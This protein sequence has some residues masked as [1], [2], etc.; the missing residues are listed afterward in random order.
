M[1]DNQCRILHRCQ[2]R[3]EHKCPQVHPRMRQ[4]QTRMLKAQFPPEQQ[5]QIQ[6]A[7]PPALLDLASNRSFCDFTGC[8][9]RRRD[10]L[11][12]QRNHFLRQQWPSLESALL[13]LRSPL[14]RRRGCRHSSP[15]ENIYR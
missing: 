7:W 8:C 11:L 4:H 14:P 1:T 5:I 2:Q 10:Q 3:P 6:R 9:H 15:K 12:S 13:W